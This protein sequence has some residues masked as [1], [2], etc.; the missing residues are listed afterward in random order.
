[1]KIYAKK[2][3]FIPR[4]KTVRPKNA[5]DAEQDKQIENVKDAVI[6][7]KK[8]LA[9]DYGVKNSY[10]ASPQP[11]TFL[12]PFVQLLNGL[13]KGDDRSSRHG[14]KAVMKYM[15]CNIF[16]GCGSI[17]LSTAVNVRVMIVR[18]KPANQTTINLTNLLDD[19]NPKSWYLQNK[20]GV[21]PKRFTIYYDKNFDMSGTSPFTRVIRIRRR[22]GFV[23]NYSKGNVGT[24]TDIDTNSFYL[25]ATTDWNGANSPVI[26]HDCNL[27]FLP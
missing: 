4:K 18:E 9:T 10:Y 16:L 21:D 17:A 14:D 7:I 6:K 23:T 13:V 2:K 22:L 19:I 20:K 24:I 25:I 15:E 12:A 11:V 27:F 5:K 3:S 1:M 8:D 26:A